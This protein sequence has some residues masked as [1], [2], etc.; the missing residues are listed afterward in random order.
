M[1]SILSMGLCPYRRQIRH[2]PLQEQN[3]KWGQVCAE[4]LPI[5]VVVGRRVKSKIKSHYFTCKYFSTRENLK[6]IYVHTIPTTASTIMKGTTNV[7]SVPLMD[8]LFASL[9]LSSR[10]KWTL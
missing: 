7:R 6:Y 10:S 8:K 2:P 4:D 9:L 5:F 1:T 3:D